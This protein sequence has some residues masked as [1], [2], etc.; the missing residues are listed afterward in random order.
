MPHVEQQTMKAAMYYG[1]HDLRI[2]EVA[3]PVPREGEVLV[4]VAWCG[5][6]GTDLHEYDAGPILVPNKQPHPI[7][8]SSLSQ[9]PVRLGHEFSGT[10]EEVGPGVEGDWKMGDR[11]VIEAVISCHKCYACRS[12]C[13]NACTSLGFVGLS[14]PSGGLAEYFSSPASFLHRLPPNVSLKAGAMC[15]PL[16]VAI[17]A[18]KRAGFEKGMKVLVC[19]AGPIGVF[20][21]VVLKAMGADLIVVSEPST[22]RRKFATLAGATQTVSPLEDPGNLLSS[23]RAMTGE[24]EGFDIAFEAAGVES[25]LALAISAVRTRG[26]VLNVSVWSKEP[27]IDMNQLVFGEKSIRGASCY[28]EDH[29]EVMRALG[30]EEIKLDQYVTSTIPLDQLIEGGFEQLLRNAENHVKILVSPSGNLDQPF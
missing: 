19:G 8:R 4:K 30:A 23:L 27:K 11:V 29:P 21:T 10:V 5:I 14:G 15:E 2:E 22:T 20:L 13:N 3:K 24:N 16:A 17:H 7:T 25:A 18:V 9:G 26:V 6:C 28:F 12:G 1:P